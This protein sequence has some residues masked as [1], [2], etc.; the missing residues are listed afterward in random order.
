MGGYSIMKKRNSLFSYLQ[1]FGKGRDA[2]FQVLFIAAIFLVNIQFSYSQ[3]TDINS[4]STVNLLD[5]SILADDWGKI[6][7]ESND[8][9]IDW[10][11][12]KDISASPNRI[13]D[14]IIDSDDNVYITTLSNYIWAI[15]KYAPESNEP[16]WTLPNIRGGISLDLNNSPYI[17]GDSIRKIDASGNTMWT[18]SYNSMRW[19][20]VAI[21]SQGFI[22]G[23]SMTDSNYPYNYAIVKFL[24]DNST[25]VWIKNGI[26]YI[27]DNTFDNDENFYF[28]TEDNLTKFDKQNG[29]ILWQYQYDCDRMYYLN[30]EHENNII[31]IG[32]SEHGILVIKH[33]PTSAEPL[34]IQEFAIPDTNCHV[35]RSAV[36]K[37]GNIYICGVAE[38]SNWN[39]L[40]IKY[41]SNGNLAWFDTYGEGYY[42]C[43]KDIQIDSKNN[44]N[45][46]ANVNKSDSEDCFTTLKYNPAGEIIWFGSY[47]TPDNETSVYEMEAT[48]MDSQDNLY[49]GGS[50]G[51]SSGWVS[52]S[53]DYVL[54][55]Y[56]QKWCSEE[57]IGDIDHNCTVDYDDLFAIANSW[58]EEI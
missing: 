47:F 4:D 2:K 22:Y 55:K 42:N 8:L 51:D 15:C 1:I 37:D 13:Y 19:N 56:K 53:Q 46:T 9:E 33:T 39:A 57:I 54:I 11:S 52:S 10:I 18:I 30:K 40:T 44:I 14:I 23:A 6:A 58:L 25:P 41:S 38:Y 16:I 43:P 35:E 49:V 21:D 24:P 50:I 12:I 27:R 3:T 48:A 45:V 17:Y 32:N 34:W 5:Y 26:G 28:L 36:D 29:E 31:A 7:S 20:S